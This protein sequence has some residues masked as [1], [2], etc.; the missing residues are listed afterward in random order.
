VPRRLT[1]TLITAAFGTVLLAG[2]SGGS[3]SADPT[4]LP[5]V[6]PSSSAPTTSSHS[7]SPTSSRPSTQTPTTK[8]AQPNGDAGAPGVPAA[9]R[10]HTK[11]GAEAFVRYY[12]AELNRAWSTPKAGL[13][14]PLSLATCRTCH[15]Y[16]DTARGG[17]QRGEHL[18]GSTTTVK[19]VAVAQWDSGQTVQLTTKRHQNGVKA[20]DSAG[21]VLKSIAPRSLQDRMV[22][23]WTRGGWRT[24]SIEVVE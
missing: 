10:K 18:D 19:S 9:A 7:P 23:S 13:L 24:Q 20:I 3:S 2:C 8:T 11:A 12:F 4:D 1:Q 22:L 14:A 5:N 21:N 17:E 15:N 16:E 6:E